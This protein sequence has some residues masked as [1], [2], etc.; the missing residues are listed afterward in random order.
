M[1]ADK[2]AHREIRPDKQLGWALG[3]L[4]TANGAT[5]P[6]EIVF[7]IFTI[8]NIDVLLRR[9]LFCDAIEMRG[10]GC[11]VEEL[12][13]LMQRRIAPLKDEAPLAHLPM[14]DYIKYQRCFMGRTRRPVIGPD[15]FGTHPLTDKGKK[16]AKRLARNYIP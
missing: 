13:F 11:A 16:K 15:V 14:G 9:L 1:P 3:L 2:N 8:P 10:P 12:L 5:L 6:G 7:P 4:A